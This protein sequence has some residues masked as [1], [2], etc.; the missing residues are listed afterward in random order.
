MAACAGSADGNALAVGQNFAVRIV[1][2]EDQARTYFEPG[3][4]S[5]VQAEVGGRRDL[6]PVGYE[7]S[8]AMVTSGHSAGSR[9]TLSNHP[10]VIV[11]PIIVSL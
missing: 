9:S 5:M 4:K 6:P 3:S 1:V 8:K 10:S 7:L 2:F 11:K